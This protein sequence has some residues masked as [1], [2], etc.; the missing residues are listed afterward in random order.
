MSRAAITCQVCHANM[1]VT[2]CMHSLLKALSLQSCGTSLQRKN[3]EVRPCTIPRGGQMEVGRRPA[4]VPFRRL[5][6]LWLTLQLESTGG[7]LNVILEGNLCGLLGAGYSASSV[8]LFLG[9][10]CQCLFLTCSSI[11]RVRLELVGVVRRN[12]RHLQH[13]FHLR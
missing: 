6:G 5:L 12:G 10:D 4:P 9:L 7:W 2:C 3:F 13:L 11:R 1:H 8:L